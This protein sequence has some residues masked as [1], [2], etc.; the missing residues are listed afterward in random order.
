[1]TEAIS[2]KYVGLDKWSVRRVVKAMYEDQIE[3]IKAVGAAQDVI[4]AAAEAAAATLGQTGRLIY[5]GAGTSGRLGVQDGSELGPTFGWPFERL[6]FCMA[7][8]AKA[9]MK[10]QEGAEDNS[11]DGKNAIIDIQANS[12]DVVF[13]IAASGRTPFTLGA[14]NEAKARGALTIGIANNALVPILDEADYAILVETGPE[15]IAGSTR[16]K[17]GT[18]QKAV[19]NILSTAIMIKLGK[20]YDGFMVDMVVSNAK[21]E[22]RAAHMVAQ[23]ANCSE[24]QARAA[25]LETGNQIKAA[26]LMCLGQS[27]DDSQILLGK[28]DGNLR[29]AIS[30]INS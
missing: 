21:L 11:E 5:V 1:M 9:L 26:V 23:I 28:S 30:E 17:A 13:C 24:Q 16:M 4:A 22:N 25:L 19:L 27:R 14:L 2:Q 18:S 15:V 6:E 3:A 12:N 8:G 10:S 7:G 29:E 20:V